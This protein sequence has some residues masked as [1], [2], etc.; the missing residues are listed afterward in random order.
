MVVFEFDG[1]TI[2]YDHAGTGDPIVFLHNLGGD[3]GIWSAQFDA[4]AAT[5]SV[6]AV[7]WFGY[8]DSTV[9][10]DGYT[11]DRYLR[12][13][14]AFVEAHDL[15]DVTLVGNCFGSAM[16]L[17][18]ARRN[19]AGVRALVLVNPLTA[20]TLRPTRSGLAARALRRV[21]LDPLGRA[22]RLP[23]AIAGLVVREQLGGRTGGEVVASLRRRWT[24]PRR[25]LPITAILREL[26][27]LAELD[28]FRPDGDFPPITTVW[29]ERNRVLSA[30]AGRRL[31]T[32]LRP[33]RSLVLPRCGHLAMVEDPDPVTDAVRAAA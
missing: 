25:L 18:H 30:A 16:S 3:R 11:I 28:T 17:L 33:D 4:L 29:G 26:P 1:L 10:D 5:R 24:E 8:G 6:Y 15:R 22:L 9:P 27:R 32:T 13:L 19:P 2:A 23:S 31:D 7:D 21:P 12:L 20:A 14:A